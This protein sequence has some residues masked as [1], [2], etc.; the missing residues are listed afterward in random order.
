MRVFILVVV[1]C[2]QNEFGAAWNTKKDSWGE[3][4]HKMKPGVGRGAREG[5]INAGD[6]QR[7]RLESIVARSFGLSVSKFSHISDVGKTIENDIGGRGMFLYYSSS[8]TALAVY[9]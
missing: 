8:P 7:S 6:R 9:L 5:Q 1:V 4:H 3:E 2:L